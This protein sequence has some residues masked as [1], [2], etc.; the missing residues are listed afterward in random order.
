MLS[1]NSWRDV[2]SRKAPENWQ[3]GGFG[4]YVHWPFCEAK[5]PYCD[6]NSHVV[7][8]ID[9]ARWARAL[10]EEIRRAGAESQ[11]R[12]LSSI[13]FGGGTPSLMAPETVAAVI[14]AARDC[15]TFANDVEITL[16]ANPRSVEAGRFEGY[17]RAGVNRV[18]LGVQSLRAE[19]LKRLGRLHDVDEARAAFG[20]ARSVFDR[21]SFDLI[22]ARQ[23][24]TLEDWRAELSEALEMAVDH[25]S[26]YQ[27]TVEE[28]TAFWD[29]ARAGGLRGLPEEDL[30][31]DMFELT[32]EL[33]Q[34]AG[35]EAYEVSNH[36]RPGAQ[37]R[38]NLVYWHYGDW[39]GVGPGAHGRIGSGATRQST[40]AW[41]AP[42]KWLEQAEAGSGLESRDLLSLEDQAGEYLMM[43]LRLTEGLDVERLRALDYGIAPDAAIRDLQGLGL[44]EQNGPMLRATGQ[45]RLV[46]NSV[47][48]ALLP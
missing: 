10:A 44:V 41:S 22:Y 47:I 3:I 16:E 18:S 38:H 43:G 45:G 39:V 8:G 12:V 48:A 15:W 40:V 26:L 31:A 2:L 17:A 21:V 9:Q 7:K 28:G 34:A 29:R 20:V 6:F 14:K 1:A 46:L 32:Q 42:G 11:G 19:D 23:N 5:C 37:S 4:L 30:A 25:M 35:Y 36:A 24:Q 27:L 33:C 13:F